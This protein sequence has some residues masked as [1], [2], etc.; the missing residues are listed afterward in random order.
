[1]PLIFVMLI[2]SAAPAF[3]TGDTSW[4]ENNA[5][6][7]STNSIIKSA[8]RGVGWTITQV[9]CWFVKV[10]GILYD[11]TFNMLDITKYSEVNDILTMLR[12]VLAALIV[13]SVAF[14]GISMIMD[15]QKKPQLVRNIV[16]GILAVTCSFYAFN[17]L[18]NMAKGFKEG[19]LGGDKIE[20]GYEDVNKNMIDLV[21]VA[22][23]N[24]GQ[25]N[26]ISY[27]DGNGISYGAGID[28]SDKMSLIDINE[29]LNYKDRSE[30]MNRYGWDSDFN[31]K[32]SKKLVVKEGQVTDTADIYSGLFTTTI[33]NEF[34]YRYKF[35]FLPCWLQL[36]AYLIM[37]ISLSFKNVRIM[38]ELVVARIL[39][40]LH[41]A[42][43]TSGERLKQILLFIRDTYIVL[44][45]SILSLKLY[46]VINGWVSL[47]IRSGGSLPGIEGDL[48]K[49]L[50]SLF[51]AFC[52]IDGPNIAERLL[53]MD[54]GL[55][56]SW[57]RIMG[58]AMI[59]GRFGS[60]FNDRNRRKGGSNRS[61]AAGNKN[62]D[63]D[64]DGGNN[65]GGRNN[66]PPPPP[67]PG[68]GSG[69]AIENMNKAMKDQQDAG[70][71]DG[72]TGGSAVS[73]ETPSGI[74]AANAPIRN[75]DEAS[76]AKA[77]LDSAAGS[78]NTSA[79]GGQTG[80]AG[81][82]DF[83][84]NTGGPDEAG[85][86][87]GRPQ[88]GS[89]NNMHVDFMERGNG[90][91]RPAAQLIPEKPT[92]T[93][94][95]FTYRMPDAGISASGISVN[96]S[97]R[98]ADAAG[99]GAVPAASAGSRSSSAGSA[100]GGAGTIPIDKHSRLK[101][102]EEASIRRSEH[103]RTVRTRSDIKDNDK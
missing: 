43:I 57:G 92:T 1:M 13:V 52:I 78:T 25:V 48:L 70:A 47:N 29:T 74:S 98:S 7:L 8:F 2:L 5:Y 89:P 19:V 88:S 12:P 55:S 86:P 40:Y 96:M 15:R 26:K 20:M 56:S 30:G 59:A 101:A 31:D 79:S 16:L 32:I 6:I 75:T 10:A 3:A 102:L 81:K 51:V 73:D 63:D 87:S 24:K 67:P 82:P 53:G 95:S 76:E 35:S 84:N 69:G 22:L 90:S 71:E 27:V 94:S 65:G 9:L 50:I 33:G 93:N 72:G 21:N 39:A 54:A 49:G 14:L 36:A 85:A 45:I 64:D 28:S 4:Y 17:L 97:E 34:Y 42:D 18:N 66:D 77:A 60:R 11:K 99:S 62:D 46:N 44:G 58:A 80:S 103:E 37:I 91:D 38:Y 61:G 23:D 83:M 100:A 68:A 41:A